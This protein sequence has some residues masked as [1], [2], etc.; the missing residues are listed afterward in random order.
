MSN[1]ETWECMN[2]TVPRWM[3]DV[4]QL[5]LIFAGSKYVILESDKTLLSQ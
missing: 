5:K 2:N 4:L 3:V 1:N